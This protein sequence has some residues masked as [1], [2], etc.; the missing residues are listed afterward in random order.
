EWLR[1]VEIVDTPG[2]SDPVASREERTADFLKRADV[3]VMMLYAGRAFDSTDTEIIFDKASRVGVGRIVLAV[4]KYDVQLLAIKP[5]T[6]EQLKT[7]VKSAIDAYLQA[8]GNEA[9]ND[10]FGSIDP[11]PLSA[12]MALIAKMPMQEINADDALRAFYENMADE[13]S[14]KSPSELGPLSLMGPVEEKIRGIIASQKEELLMRQPAA[15]IRQIAKDTIQSL[16]ERIMALEQKCEELSI[17]DGELDGR[18][19]RLDRAMRL[20]YAAIGQGKV[21]LNVAYEKAARDYIQQ[22]ENAA[23]DAKREC[24]KYANSS[25]WAKLNSEI[26]QC[27]DEFKRR[28]WPRA[29][30][31]FPYRLQGELRCHIDTLSGKV[32]DALRDCFTDF[33]Y[34][35]RTVAQFENNLMKNLGVEIDVPELYFEELGFKAKDKVEVAFKTLVPFVNLWGIPSTLYDGGRDKARIFVDDTF[36]R[37]DAAIEW[38]RLDID[39]RRHAFV[40]LLDGEIVYGLTARLKAESEAARGKKRER[41]RALADAAADLQAAKLRLA[42]MDASYSAIKQIMG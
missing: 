14:L 21:D 25:Q 4:N 31:E 42:D 32:A 6:P 7:R 41:E 20:I 12:L 26:N 13:F 38:L 8:A 36:R 17:P 23:D 29:V 11:M 10:L 18:I 37:V 34:V 5:E 1:G 33:E 9:L 27:L 28:V 35:D 30:Q 40:E 19:N 24:L 3:A 15:R 22:I 39:E 16:R 2:F